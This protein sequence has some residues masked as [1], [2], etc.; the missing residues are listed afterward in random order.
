MRKQLKLHLVSMALAAAAMTAALAILV[1]LIPSPSQML[2]VGIGDELE[3]AKP[4]TVALHWM[5][6]ETLGV[7]ALP[8]L[9]EALGSDRLDVST[10]ARKLIDL[11]FNR[12]QGLSPDVAS[13][14]VQQLAELLSAQV[15]SYSATSREHARQLTL[16][17][18]RWPIDRATVD[19]TQ[20][21]ATCEI[22]LRTAGENLPAVLTDE[23]LPQTTPVATRIEI[24]TVDQWRARRNRN[25]ALYGDQNDLSLRHPVPPIPPPTMGVLHPPVAEDQSRSVG[26]PRTGTLGL[27]QE[28]GLLPFERRPR[29]MSLPMVVGEQPGNSFPIA[30]DPSDGA[31]VIPTVDELQDA[32]PIVIMRWLLDPNAEAIAT[33]ALVRRGF[34]QLEIRVARQIVDP[35]P[36]E[37]LALAQALPNIPVNDPRPWLLWLSHDDDVSVRKATVAILATNPDPVL[38]NRLRELELEETDEGVLAVVKQAL[39]QSRLGL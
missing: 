1:W 10:G 38:Q 21:I 2:A 39:E 30:P 17:I 31:R 23:T 28:P 3:T 15:A 26:S 9:V 12:W 33:D 20:L 25:A 6:L 8:T 24:E 34:S 4:E 16:R 5:Q 22:V 35:D 29:D 7:A 27:A 36:K 14:N 13:K 32:E 37:R 18:L 19:R 11:E